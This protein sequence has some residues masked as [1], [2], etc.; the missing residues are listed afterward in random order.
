ML[1]WWLGG[2][3]YSQVAMD[4]DG[5]KGPIGATSR[6]GKGDG[7]GLEQWRRQQRESE[8]GNWDLGL[9]VPIR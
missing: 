9:V 5:E 2:A 4:D 3:L 7:G 1:R 8:E 6:R